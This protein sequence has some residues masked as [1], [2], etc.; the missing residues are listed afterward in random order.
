MQALAGELELPARSG[1]GTRAGEGSA[2]NCHRRR[3]LKPG[4]VSR[5]TS[6]AVLPG[7]KL[8]MTA[9]RN[10]KPV[11]KYLS[12][13]CVRRGHTYHQAPRSAHTPE[14]VQ[15][16]LCAGLR[17][18]W[19]DGTQVATMAIWCWC[20]HGIFRA[21][22]TDAA[23]LTSETWTPVLDNLRGHSM[24]YLAHGRMDPDMEDQ[25]QQQAH[26]PVGVR[27]WEETLGACK[28]AHN[29]LADVWTEWEPSSTTQPGSNRYFFFNHN[30]SGCGPL[31]PP[32]RPASRDL[33]LMVWAQ[34]S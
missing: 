13:V 24:C 14:V 7:L 29:H 27:S 32:C 5:C 16:L 15:L 28:V 31:A 20:R 4:V 2:Q 18:W 11:P 33:H 19:V 10:P 25:Q 1:A 12:P 17:L 21:A 30:V 6:G 34:G 8:G 26:L 22:L 3:P 9:N 23:G